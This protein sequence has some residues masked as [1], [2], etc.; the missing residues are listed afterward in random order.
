LKLLAWAY[1]WFAF[2]AKDWTW[3]LVEN[4]GEDEQ[5]PSARFFIISVCFDRKALQSESRH[6]H[7][8]VI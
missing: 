3:Q 1:I 5:Y 4:K 2:L 7:T 6:F 8:A